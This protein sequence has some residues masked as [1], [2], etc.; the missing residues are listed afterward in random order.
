MIF[1]LKNTGLSFISR[2]LRGGY[3]NIF[4]NGVFSRIFAGFY[5]IPST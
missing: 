4:I 3:L 2:T 5:L 1:T